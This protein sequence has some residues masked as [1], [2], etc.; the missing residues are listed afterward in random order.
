MFLIIDRDTYRH[1]QTNRYIPLQYNLCL[2]E[3]TINI[4]IKVEKGKL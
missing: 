1:R 2:K 4:Y 3:W